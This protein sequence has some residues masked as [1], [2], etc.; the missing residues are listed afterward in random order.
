MITGID[1]RVI[2]EFMQFCRFTDNF[3]LNSSEY[4]LTVGLLDRYKS[5][6]RR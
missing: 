6:L 2:D 3:I 5:F 1:D 4:Q